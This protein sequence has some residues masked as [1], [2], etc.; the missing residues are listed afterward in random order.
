MQCGWPL[1]ILQPSEVC[2]NIIFIIPAGRQIGLN[3]AEKHFGQ[4]YRYNGPGIWWSSRLMELKAVQCGWKKKDVWASCVSWGWRNRQVWLSWPSRLMGPPTEQSPALSSTK[5]WSSISHCI[6][7]K[8]MSS[9][10][11]LEWVLHIYK[12]TSEG[13]WK[14]I[15][16]IRPENVGLRDRC[17]T[18]SISLL[19]WPVQ[20][21][22]NPQS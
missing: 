10:S 19:L 21:I 13:S 16:E 20:V 3:L 9:D 7:G 2:A 18:T 6:D 5:F 11:S 8:Q 12:N 4:W 22:L 15:E 1:L 17:T 14:L